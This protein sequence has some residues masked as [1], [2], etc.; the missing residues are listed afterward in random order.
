[1][2][3]VAQMYIQVVSTRDVEKVMAEFGL[4]AAHIG[5]IDLLATGIAD[6]D[7]A[8]FIRYIRAIQCVD[9]FD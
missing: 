2:L 6:M 4:V 7:I 1:M 3:A 9:G 8:P 5:L